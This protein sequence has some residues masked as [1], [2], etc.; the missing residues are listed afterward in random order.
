MWAGQFWTVLGRKS[1]PGK[2][3]TGPR[4]LLGITRPEYWSICGK[5]LWLSPWIHAND[6]F[7]LSLV[8][9]NTLWQIFR[10][11]GLPD[12]MAFR[13]L[14]SI[15]CGLF[16]YKLE[17]RN[18]API[19][20]YVCVFICFATKDQS[21]VSL[22]HGLKHFICARRKYKQNCWD[23]AT[24]FKSS[25]AVT[26]HHKS[27]HDFCLSETI[28][29]HFI[30]PR[31]TYFGGLWDAAVK[32]TIYYFLSCCE[33]FSPSIRWTED[34]CMPYSAVINSK[35]LVSLSDLIWM[36]LPHHIFIDEPDVTSLIYKLLAI[37]LAFSIE[38]EVII[39]VSYAIKTLN[40]GDCD[41][42]YSSSD[43]FR[44]MTH[45]FHSLPAATRG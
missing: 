17:A 28:D 4:A 16:F 37:F 40:S 10:R 8:S 13:S 30:P 41:I 31:S 26:T 44:T 9:G 21:T 1:E 25:L 35:P 33:F 3:N 22:I 19:K 14:E 36:F 12:R 43:D 39:G 42:Q 20:C 5:R 7:G 15:F 34:S 38:L 18:T 45:H 2:N 11:S 32:T 6:V 27:V 29:W 24:Y 23:N